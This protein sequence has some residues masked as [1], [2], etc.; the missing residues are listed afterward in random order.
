M[1]KALLIPAS[2]FGAS[3]VLLGLRLP[4]VSVAPTG[5][6]WT[7]VF[8]LLNPPFIVVQLFAPHGAHEL[9]QSIWPQ[10][11]YLVAALTALVWWSSIAW[12]LH[13]R[14]IRATA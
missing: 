12:F 6:A 7:I 5:Q 9:E 14:A 2:G 1:N 4:L 13:R 3:L 11:E 8:Y 10:I